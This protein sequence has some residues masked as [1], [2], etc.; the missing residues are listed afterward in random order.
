M[1]I[2]ITFSAAVIFV[3]GLMFL[4][5]DFVNIVIRFRRYPL[6]YNVVSLTIMCMAILV[7]GRVLGVW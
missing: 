7:S 4:M 6:A 5:V 1:N 3:V 2:I